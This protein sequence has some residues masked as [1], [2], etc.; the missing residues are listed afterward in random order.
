MQ[1]SHNRSFDQDGGRDLW[2]NVISGKLRDP[3]T[4]CM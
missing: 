1:A 4:F 3:M 2:V